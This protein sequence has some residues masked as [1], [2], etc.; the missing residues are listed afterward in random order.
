[1]N[2]HFHQLQSDSLVSLLIFSEFIKKIAYVHTTFLIANDI[3]LL[4]LLNL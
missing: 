3:T 1:M 2:D 4:L